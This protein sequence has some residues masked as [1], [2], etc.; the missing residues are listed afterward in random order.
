[1]QEQPVPERRTHVVNRSVDASTSTFVVQRVIANRKESAIH[2]I[3]TTNLSAC[4]AWC[5]SHRT[6][7]APSAIHGRPADRLRPLAAATHREQKP[8]QL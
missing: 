3:A 7:G 1:M 4:G 2:S 8:M 6:R 5:Y